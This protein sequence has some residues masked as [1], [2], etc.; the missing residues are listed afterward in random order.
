MNSYLYSN[1]DNN[2]LRRFFNSDTLDNC[3]YVYEDVDPD[4]NFLNSKTSVTRYY[5]PFQLKH[6][7][8][9]TDEFFILHVNSRS[10]NA[11]FSSNENLTK[12][13]DNAFNIL[14]VTETWLNET[15]SDIYSNVWF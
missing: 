4:V 8:K 13:L 10:L 1:L 9:K 11:N 5:T 14:P 3:K 7:L 2:E 15:N 12:E 6:L